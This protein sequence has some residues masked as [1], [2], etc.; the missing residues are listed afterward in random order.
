MN[1]IF[2]NI[3]NKN[4]KIE[5]VTGGLTIDKGDCDLGHIDCWDV[6]SRYTN[7]CKGC[8]TE[9][10]NTIEKLKKG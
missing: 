9:I 4:I 2:C 3:C 7:I 1:K 8:L 6:V 5:D 10:E